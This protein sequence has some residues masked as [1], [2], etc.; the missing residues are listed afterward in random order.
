MDLN[1]RLIK[2]ITINKTT[3][4]LDMSKYAAGIYLLKLENGEVI[5]ILKQ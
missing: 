4:V 1:G 2:E 5:K 3:T